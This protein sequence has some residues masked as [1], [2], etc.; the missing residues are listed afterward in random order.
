MVCADSLRRPGGLTTWLAFSLTA[1]LLAGCGI[2]GPTAPPPGTSVPAA[3]MP[4][5]TT[6]ATSSPPPVSTSPSS[7]PSAQTSPKPEDATGSSAASASPSAAARK[8]AWHATGKTIEAHLLGTATTLPDGRVLLAGGKASTEGGKPGASAELYDPTTG[9]WTA[10]GS[11]ARARWGH[12]ATL[13][14]GGGCL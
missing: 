5:A 8:A 14:E 9:K 13:L 1:V 7:G 10:T 11:M 12:T 4:T 3:S 2:T 6:A